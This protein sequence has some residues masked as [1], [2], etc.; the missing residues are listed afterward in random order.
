MHHHVEVV[1]LSVV[2]LCCSAG[3]LCVMLTAE[4]FLRAGLKEY[5]LARNKKKL[6]KA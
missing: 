3:A 4:S 5:Y 2:F 1:T 6:E